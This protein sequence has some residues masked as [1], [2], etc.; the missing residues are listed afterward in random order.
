MNGPQKMV[1]GAVRQ[2]LGDAL[3]PGLLASGLNRLRRFRR[4][5]SL[6]RHRAAMMKAVRSAASGGVLFK[7]S[8]LSN[9]LRAIRTFEQVNGIPFDPFNRYHCS[10]VAG[11]GSHEEL[12]R[13]LR[14]RGLMPYRGE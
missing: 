13:K 8:S 7:D 12:F 4:A 11:G 6:S 10:L 5:A 1:L 2:H 14:L 9:G 3:R